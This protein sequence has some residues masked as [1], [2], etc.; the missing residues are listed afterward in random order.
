MLE[1][2]TKVMSESRWSMGLADVSDVRDV[3]NSYEE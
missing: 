2:W 3:R 1:G